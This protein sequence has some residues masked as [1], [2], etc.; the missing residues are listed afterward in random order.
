MNAAQ[1]REDTPDDPFG[2]LGDHL[3]LQSPQ[4]PSEA[5]PGGIEDSGSTDVEHPA[6]CSCG[7]RSA[8]LAPV[9]K[10]EWP[11]DY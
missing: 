8:H 6:G 2:A 10:R 9:L 4:G 11:Y 1:E 7:Y 5:Y 3:G